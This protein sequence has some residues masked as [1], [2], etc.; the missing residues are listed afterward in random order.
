MQ[1]ADRPLLASGEGLGDLHVPEHREEDGDD[2]VVALEPEPPRRRLV[3]DDDT[4]GGLV[5]GEDPGPEPDP[6]T[7]FGQEGPGQLVHSPIDGDQV[8]VAATDLLAQQLQ[9]GGVE[10]CL[11]L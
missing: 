3:V 2:R 6:I 4:F 8:G 7:Q 10:Q 11:L 9:E 5:E 1:L